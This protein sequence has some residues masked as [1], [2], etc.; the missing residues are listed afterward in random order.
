MIAISMRTLYVR[1][2][3]VF[4]AACLILS[5]CAD[6]DASYER[7]QRAPKAKFIRFGR[8]GQKFIRFGRS[9]GGVP[10]EDMAYWMAEQGRVY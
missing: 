3:L 10:N 7:N 2:L 5:V 9:N 8:A 6:D 4:L 1:F